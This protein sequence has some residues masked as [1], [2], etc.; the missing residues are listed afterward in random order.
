MGISAEAQKIIEQQKKL[1]DQFIVDP[2]F[3]VPDVQIEPFT[4][5]LR[6]NNFVQRGLSHLLGK[7]AANK[8][9]YPVAVDDEGKLVFSDDATKAG[10]IGLS[11]RECVVYKVFD[12]VSVPAT[13]LVTHDG[14]DIS[15]YQEVSFAISTTAN[16]AIYLQFS[17]DNSNW[18]DLKAVDDSDRSWNCTNEKIFATN[19]VAAHYIRIVVYATV[20]STVTGIITGRC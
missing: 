11:K 4:P 8:K 12:S 15:S 13:S 17:D 10:W 14:V 5:H 16:C 2:N 20:A 9:W 19:S 1:L 6:T 3:L 18:Y 7:Y